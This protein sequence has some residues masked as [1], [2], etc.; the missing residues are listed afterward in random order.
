M[1]IEL[2][3]CD[4][5][6]L[7][8]TGRQCMK[9][10][11]QTGLKGLNK[12]AVGGLDGVLQI[13]TINKG[14][15]QVSFKT[16]PGDP[17]RVLQLGGSSGMI[18]DKIFVASKTEV[19]GYTKKGKLFLGLDTNMTEHI[20]SMEVVGS[21][22]LVAGNHLYNHYRDCKDLNSYLSSDR[23]NHLIALP[24]HK[25]HRIITVLACEDRMLRVL[26]R[27]IVTETVPLP[28][29]PVLLT[30]LGGTGGD[31][32]ECIVVA[33]QN[34]EIAMYNIGRGGA[35]WKWTIPN[36]QRR[37]TVTCMCWYDIL[38]DGTQQLIVGRE[39]GSLQIYAEPIEPTSQSQPMNQIY[40]YSCSESIT[41]VQGGNVGNP[42]F[43]EIVVTTY[44]GWFFGLTTEVLDKQVSWEN[45]N[46]SIKM[47][48]KEKQKIENLRAEVDDLERS[49]YRERER[50]QLTTQEDSIG[51]ST[52]S[53]LAINDK[54]T[55]VNDHYAYQLSLEAETAI[56]NVL[57]QSNVNIKL[58]DSEKN[59][60]VVSHSIP[61]PA[62]GC[63]LLAT[64]RCQSDTSKMNLIL[65]Y[66]NESGYL[67]VYITPQSKPKTTHL[68]Q[69]MIRKLGMLS[70]THDSGEIGPCNVLRLTGSFSQAEMHNWLSKCLPQVPEKMPSSTTVQYRYV[71]SF[72][73]TQL[74]LQYSKGEAELKS[75]DISIISTMKDFLTNQ[76]TAKKIRLDIA[77]EVNIESIKNILGILYPKMRAEFEGEREKLLYEALKDI[78]M[79][80]TDGR[81]LLTPYC[82]QIVEKQKSVVEKQGSWHRLEKIQDYVLSLYAD[83]CKFH[84]VN[85]KVKQNKLKEM[86]RTCSLEELLSLFLVGEH[87]SPNQT[88]DEELI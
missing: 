52:V 42:A 62:N 13:F 30:L 8:L 37:E 5:C 4:Y 81:L 74:L 78:E 50:Y 3:R 10:L 71:S 79:S 58:L 47:T 73:G 75:D 17:I 1:S 54:M 77:F 64:Y 67:N 51:I 65:Q 12:V 39:D 80:E 86:L 40:N 49:L 2:A 36:D 25:S 9:L 87:S 34:G 19:R 53:P 16:L 83:W 20:N 88:V 31:N 38:R 60:A 69:Y 29:A 76:A 27:G 82:R 33:L 44:T 15:V 56:E 66:G 28:S 21:D 59:S 18:Q 23:I 63:N 14:E 72:I 26:D 68:K 85:S 55:F 41:S 22:L 24:L 45:N 32:G 48:P 11:P 43:P 61:D 35:E 57:L 84:E 46:I 6:L 7:G 70:R